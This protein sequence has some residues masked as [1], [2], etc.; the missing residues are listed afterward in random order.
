M[1][2]EKFR[3]LVFD[4]SEGDLNQG[5]K[6]EVERHLIEC[7][8]CNLYFEKSHK[9]WNLLGKFD[10]IEVKDDFVARFWDRASK[11]DRKKAGVFDFF[12]NLRVNLVTGLAGVLIL[13]LGILLVNTFVSRQ[14]S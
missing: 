2:C 13:I 14:Y 6:L 1:R 9:M 11:E 12:G 10:T 7:S 3:E 5:E 8:D 4:Y